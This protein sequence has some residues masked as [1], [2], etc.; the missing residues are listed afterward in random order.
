MHTPQQRVAAIVGADIVVITIQ[1][2]AATTLT[3]L[4]KVPCCA[5]VAVGTHGII[6]S[7]QAALNL[8]TRVVGTEVTI[9][10][11][12]GSPCLT[13]AFCTT[14]PDSATVPIVTGVAPV[15][16]L[17]GT[18][19]CSMVADS[20]ETDGVHSGWHWTDHYRR[21]IYYAEVGKLGS[22]AKQDP[23]ADVAIFQ[24]QTIGI[25]K[26]L[27]IDSK[28][29]TLTDIA[30]VFHGARITIIAIGRVM[31]RGTATKSITQIVGAWIVV[32]ADHG[33]SNTNSRLT[34]IADRA[35]IVIATFASV[36]I[37]MGTT[38]FPAAYITG[39]AIAII[40]KLHVLAVNEVRLVHFPV[41]IVVNP[42]AELCTCNQGVTGRETLGCTNT[43]PLA[44][45]K[46]VGQ[47]AGGPQRQ[48]H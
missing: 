29:G 30:S 39:A 33:R 40:T 10:T 21:R 18:G 2:L 6:G 7:V 47:F 43:L 27:T 38:G 35:G 37:F 42:V 48:F 20:F 22:I 45:S 1:H 11:I 34:M 3:I 25:F 9:V 16:C 36:Q 4:A 26:A 5:S 46:L 23:I 32:I 19:T 44:G 14:V 17:H 24:G 8:L 12:G 28:A 31:F 13:N 41:T 15:C